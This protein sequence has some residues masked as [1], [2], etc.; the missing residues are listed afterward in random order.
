VSD[1][2]V[3]GNTRIFQ[4]VCSSNGVGRFSLHRGTQG[5]V[6]CLA[7]HQVSTVL[8]D[9]SVSSPRRLRNFA[10]LLLCLLQVAG[11]SW[12]LLSPDPFAVVR[13]TSL[14]W[15]QSVSDLLMHAF[16]FTALSATVLSLCL[17]IFGEVPPV[18]VFA[19]LGYCL[20]LEGLQAFV[21]GRT[22]DPRDA[23]ANVAG[24]V[25]GLSCVRILSRFRP[26][27]TRV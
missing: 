10:H 24:F 27:P 2:L 6:R 9:D 14:H 19:M 7:R 8:N 26:A 17:A 1:E 5:Q 18:A 4:R 16:V 15:V 23:I 12:A 3:S 21:P 11:V 13:D 25:L 22:C 20:T